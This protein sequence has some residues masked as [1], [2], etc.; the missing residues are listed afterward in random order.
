VALLAAGFAARL[1]L[2]WSTFLN[3][4]EAWHYLLAAQPSLRQAYQ[5]SLTTAHP[6]L[7]ILLIWAWQHAGISEF[8]L[9]LPSVL[10]GTAFC[11]VMFRWMQ[12]TLGYGAALAALPLTLFSPPL[13]ALSAEVRQ[14]ALLLLFCT[15]S[16]Y[17]FDQ[18]VKARSGCLMLS[19]QI[20]LWLA[21]MTHY[22]SVIFAAA[23]GIYGLL[24]LARSN[25][26][27]PPV[28]AWGLGQLAGTS[29][30]A[31]QY[32]RHVRVLERSG[33]SQEI[34]A[35]YLR[36]SLFHRDEN[37]VPA[38]LW[39]SS[40]HLFRYFFSN[41][42]VGV[43]ALLLFLG[44]A[45]MLW[46]DREQAD[47]SR[48]A[49]RDLAVLLL[50]PFLLTATLALAGMYPFGGV[51][52]D[53]L[54]A[55][56]GM[57]LIAVGIARLPIPQTWAKAVVV[58]GV[59][60]LGNLHPHPL[61]PYISPR[62]QQKRLMHA[63]VDYLRE[64]KASTTILTDYEGGL[65]LSYYLC[66]QTV[67]N[68]DPVAH[69]MRQSACGARQVIT[70][71]EDRFIFTPE[72]FARFRNDAAEEGL[73]RKNEPAWAFQAG[74]IGDPEENLIPETM[75]PPCLKL[76]RFGENIFACLFSEAN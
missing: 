51:R 2:A 25:P 74:W 47:D 52:H 14:Y 34:A 69:A 24:R 70:P 13:I 39:K 38:F 45:A 44:G 62:D 67:V 1:W 35:S 11:W 20:S 36:T 61:G 56:F 33:L 23:F 50:L 49:S 9:R 5:A 7:F 29:L 71:G 58:I 26:G 8:W 43:V 55:P 64:S 3:P 73:I 32:V 17:A 15:V 6:P 21:L 60:A 65:L 27:S 30:V 42:A 31:W 57:A 12:T 37:S 22:S 16:L 18:A 72:S 68:L 48:P 28:A 40:S 10:A 41:G 76:R 63:A 59:L 54:L 19:S 4:D 53:I 75:E 66:G 46:S